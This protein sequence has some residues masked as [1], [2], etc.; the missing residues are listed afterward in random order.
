VTEAWRATADP[1]TVNNYAIW[2]NNLDA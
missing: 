2:G 1:E